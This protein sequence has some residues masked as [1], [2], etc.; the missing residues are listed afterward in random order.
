MIN[1][2]REERKNF[3]KKNFGHYKV[4]F[5]VLENDDVKAVDYS[6]VGLG[7]DARDIPVTSKIMMYHE[8][9][10]YQL[11]LIHCHKIPGR[12][13]FSYRLGFKCVKNISHIFQ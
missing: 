5:S 1:S 7:M 6:S 8:N 3:G 10:S 13:D 9:D 4:T 11:I 12:E 2:N